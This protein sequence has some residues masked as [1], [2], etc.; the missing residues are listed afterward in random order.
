MITKFHGINRHKKYFTISVLNRK[1]EE[2]ERHLRCS[3]LKYISSTRVTHFQRDILT[4]NSQLDY[5]AAGIS[6]IWYVDSKV[7]C[8]RPDHGCTQGLVVLLLG[9]LYNEKLQIDINYL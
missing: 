8:E 5:A 6:Y 4:I 1:G 3:D 7:H 9:T 2:V